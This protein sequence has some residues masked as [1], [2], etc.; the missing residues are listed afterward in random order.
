[1][2]ATRINHVSIGAQD[3]EES[4][5][6]YE[7]VFG[8]ERVPSPNFGMPVYWLLIGDTQLHLFHTDTRVTG[9]QHLGIEVD[10]F[11][12]VYRRL[13]ER[14][15][16]EPYGYFAQMVELPDGAVQLYFRDPSGNLV[17]IDHPDVTKLDRSLFGDR[18][19]RLVDLQPQSAE[20]LSATLWAPPAPRTGG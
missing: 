11:E 20:N 1:M 5:R 10:D 8:L 6:F 13:L 18:L 2:R 3:V 15:M 17:E 9:T 19:V 16:F 14:G 4:G 7:E 12:G